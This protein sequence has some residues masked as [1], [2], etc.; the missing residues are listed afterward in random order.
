MSCGPTLCLV[1]TLLTLPKKGGVLLMAK[2]LKVCRVC[3]KEYEA[4]R[5]AATSFRWQEVACSPECGQIY[6]KKI[7][8][9]RRAKEPAYVPAKREAKKFKASFDRH[10]DNHKTVDLENKMDPADNQESIV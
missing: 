6:L 4:C 7:E 5:T 8:E 9:S 10:E 2:A 3:G 1:L